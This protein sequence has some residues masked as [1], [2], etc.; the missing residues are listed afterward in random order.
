[1]H[2]NTARFD[3]KRPRVIQDDMSGVRLL[4]PAND[5]ES[6]W[7]FLEIF[8]YSRSQKAPDFGIRH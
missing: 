5:R 3:R 4:D 7:K 1:M 2:E 6:A 8:D